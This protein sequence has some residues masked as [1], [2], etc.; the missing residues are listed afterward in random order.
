M[1]SVDACQGYFLRDFIIDI[2]GQIQAKKGILCQNDTSLKWNLSGLFSDPLQRFLKP[3]QVG[4]NRGE[5][6]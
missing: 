3:N 5:F 2:N 4:L 6:A 1:R